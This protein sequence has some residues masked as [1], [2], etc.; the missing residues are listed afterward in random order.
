MRVANEQRACR[1]PAFVLGE[2][3]LQ[4]AREV[5]ALGQRRARQRG[6]EAR[7]NRLAL[8][9]SARLRSGSHRGPAQAR[10]GHRAERLVAHRLAVIDEHDVAERHADLQPR[11]FLY[12]YAQRKRQRVGGV[13]ENLGDRLRRVHRRFVEQAARGIGGRLHVGQPHRPALG[14][15]GV[16]FLEGR[17]APHL[18]EHEHVVGLQLRM[19]ASQRGARRSARQAAAQVPPG[20]ERQRVQV[21]RELDFMC[22]LEHQ[23]RR[24]RARRAPP[25][26]SAPTAPGDHRCG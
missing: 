1:P 13:P 18:L 7:R 17:G 14:A 10:L 15:I 9:A 5:E 25:C 4:I 8:C 21:G 19:R 2:R 16:F 23:R 24:P 3:N 26:C 20:V 11:P 6:A 12:R 22:R